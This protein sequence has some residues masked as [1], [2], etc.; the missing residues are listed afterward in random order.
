ML[1]VNAKLEEMFEEIVKKEGG[2]SNNTA[3]KG[4]ATKHGV[5]IGTLSQVLG[6][7]A[8][9]KDVR[10][11]TKEQAVDIYFNLYYYKPNICALPPQ[12]QHI[13]TDMSVNHGPGKAISML[14]EVIEA[15]GID[16]GKV[17][18]DIGPA[19]VKG[20]SELLAK[21]GKDDFIN[22][23]VQRRKALYRNIVKNDPTQKVFLNGWLARADSFLIA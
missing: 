11:L 9:E 1:E 7:K 4:K 22:K 20:A 19:T 12:L 13:V 6:R 10:A 16:I 21:I 15:C 17:D 23:L 5:T 8:T 2:F 18:G 14:Q 3:D